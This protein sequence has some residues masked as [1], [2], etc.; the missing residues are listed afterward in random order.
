MFI[1]K[2][3]QGFWCSFSIFSTKKLFFILKILA[4]IFKSYIHRDKNKSSFLCFLIWNKNYEWINLLL[5]QKE[6][7]LLTSSAVAS[8]LM[9]RPDV[10]GGISTSGL[11]WF[12]SLI[13]HGRSSSNVISPLSLNSCSMYI[14][15]YFSFTPSSLQFVISKNWEDIQNFVLFHVFHVIPC[16]NWKFLIHWLFLDIL[17]S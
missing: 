4:P 13:H 2:F 5:L 8:G 3:P 12:F 6:A 15:G 7:A 14:F 11:V 1:P 16:L 10:R 17:K 9:R